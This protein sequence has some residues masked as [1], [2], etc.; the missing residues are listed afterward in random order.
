MRFERQRETK[1]RIYL[2]DLAIRKLPNPAS[3]DVK[4]W[5]TTTPA[6]GIRCTARTKS[7]FVVYGVGRRLTT[8]GRYGEI[9]LSQAR[10]EARRHWCTRRQKS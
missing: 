1:L 8:I 3:G 7:F 10:T 4:Y 6:F 2:T 5:D 9:S